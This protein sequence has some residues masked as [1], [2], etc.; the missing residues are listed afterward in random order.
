MPARNLHVGGRRFTV[1]FRN[2]SAEQAVLERPSRPPP[3]RRYRRHLHRHGSRSGRPAPDAQ[4]AHH[5]G[6][7]GGRRA[8][9]RAHHPRR[10]AAGLRRH[11]RVR[12]RHHARHQRGDRAARR[13][14]G[15]GRDRRLPRRA[16]YRQREP[17]RPVR[18]DHREAA[19]A[20]AARAAPDGAGARRRARRGAAA[21]RR[22]GGASTG[23][24]PARRAHRE[25]G[26]RVPA[27]L[28][29]PG[30]RAAH[31]RDPAGGNAGPVGDL[32]ERGVPGGARVRAHQHHCRQRLCAAA[33][34]RL[35]RTHAGGA[36][37]RRLRR[38]DLSRHLG[39][40][41]DG[42]RDGAQVSGAA[43]RIRARRRRH[44]RGPGSSPRAAKAAH[45]P[46]TWAA[47]P[48][49]SA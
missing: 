37:G 28:R 34:G 27:F 8:H 12:A 22:G 3:R 24:V 47:P 45:C 13:A 30:A 2:A 33:D 40:R 23:A 18:P 20:G 26:D 25:C 19:A 16:R 36:E 43:G 39:R 15:A 35:S 4:G 49:R 31:A 9:R 48:P 14:H 7:A 1:G 32:V 41:P 17:L 6:A 10:R 29:Q 38:H 21:A 42:D 5:A 44:L 11:R 46:S